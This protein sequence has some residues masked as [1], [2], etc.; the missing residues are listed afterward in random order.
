MDSS[1]NTILEAITIHTSLPEEIAEQLAKRIHGALILS[2][3][4]K[5]L[6]AEISAWDILAT[7]RNELDNLYSAIDSLWVVS[8]N[9][10]KNK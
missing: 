3:D 6:K 1:T 10:N 5:L 8:I 4:K 7:Y 2:R 9:N